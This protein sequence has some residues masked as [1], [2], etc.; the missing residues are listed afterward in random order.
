LK[1][2]QRSLVIALALLVTTAPARAFYT[3]CAARED[4]TPANR[5]NGH[6]DP[7]TPSLEKGMKAAFRD[8]FGDWWFVTYTAFDTQYYGW[9]P[10]NV[11]ARCQKMDGTP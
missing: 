11:L 10:R 9:V 3:E 7:R 2:T 8:S 1:F 4:F 6:A 5:P